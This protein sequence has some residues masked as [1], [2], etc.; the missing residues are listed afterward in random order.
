MSSTKGS[1]YA[2]DELRDDLSQLLLD[3]LGDD[4]LRYVHSSDLS[5]NP[6]TGADG[7]DEALAEA[8]YRR[9]GYL[10]VPGMAQQNFE[11]IRDGD[12]EQAPSQRWSSI[13]RHQARKSSAPH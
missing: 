6:D 10:P 2:P 12:A 11:P 5:R 13:Q 3:R 4:L 1:V 8:C 7:T 9:N